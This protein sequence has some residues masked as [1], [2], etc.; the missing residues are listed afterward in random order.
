MPKMLINDD[1]RKK[2]MQAIDSGAVSPNVP[3][4]TQ[5]AQL[6]ILRKVPAKETKSVSR[7]KNTTHLN[8]TLAGGTT[9]M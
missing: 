8:T 5:H 4:A 9:S 7:Q 6:K 3:D 2:I 1:L